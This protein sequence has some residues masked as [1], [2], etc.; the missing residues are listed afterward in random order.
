MLIPIKNLTYKV[1]KATTF[2]T[3][4]YLDFVVGIESVATTLKDMGIDIKDEGSPYQIT[5]LFEINISDTQNI[6]EIKD[7]IVNYFLSYKPKNEIYLSYFDRKPLIMSNVNLELITNEEASYSRETLGF[8][9]QRSEWPEEETKELCKEIIYTIMRADDS[10]YFEHDQLYQ[11]LYDSIFSDNSYF[12]FGLKE[13]YEFLQEE[14]QEK[15]TMNQTAEIIREAE[16]IRNIIDANA[17]K[18]EYTEEELK[19]LNSAI[20]KVLERAFDARE[21]KI[22]ELED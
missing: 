10:K 15:D 18:R 12:A 5:E 2:E 13:G 16:S 21:R 11:T 7:R 19:E 14:S 17:L 8:G 3:A 6:E 22:K 20:D 9:F 4:N 1:E